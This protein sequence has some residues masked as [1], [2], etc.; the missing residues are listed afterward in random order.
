ML[1]CKTETT[2]HL[3]QLCFTESRTVEQKEALESWLPLFYVN[4]LE[5]EKIIPWKMPWTHLS[6]FAPFIPHILAAI[7]ED[8]TQKPSML[9]SI[10]CPI[11]PKANAIEREQMEALNK[12]WE[13]NYYLF[14][15]ELAHAEIWLKFCKFLHNKFHFPA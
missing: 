11:H 2:K 9:V 8:I 7:E 12:I 14:I 5:A 6:E 3:A 1:N 10:L 15:P 4:P 13:Q